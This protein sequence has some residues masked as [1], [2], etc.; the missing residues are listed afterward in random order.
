M[1]CRSHPGV[2]VGPPSQLVTDLQRGRKIRFIRFRRALLTL[3]MVGGTEGGEEGTGRFEGG[4]AQQGR[5][6]LAPQPP[7]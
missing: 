4:S 5:V 1:V 3:Q 2:T 6:C 7:F